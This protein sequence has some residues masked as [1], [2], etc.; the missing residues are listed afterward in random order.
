MIID[1]EDG[2]LTSVL[3]GLKWGGQSWETSTGLPTGKETFGTINTNGTITMN[4]SSAA[5]I[6]I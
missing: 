3:G 1:S 6:Y 2:K 4:A 5:L